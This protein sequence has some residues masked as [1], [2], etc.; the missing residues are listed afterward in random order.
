MSQFDVYENTDPDSMETYPYFVD[1][2]NPLLDTLNSR[3][4]MPLTSSQGSQGYPKNL[5]PL[6]EIEGCSYALLAQQIT[7][8]PS[9]LLTHQP[10]PIG[11]YRNDIIAALDFL[12]SGI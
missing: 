3:V 4:V 5:C 10:K 12:I 7:T 11:L 6:I 9:S 1:I 8:I 2:Q